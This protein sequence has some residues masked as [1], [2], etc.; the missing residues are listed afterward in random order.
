MENYTER[1]EQLEQN[2]RESDARMN[3][4][5]KELQSFCRNLLTAMAS[6]CIAM[7]VLVVLQTQVLRTSK[8]V[9]GSAEKRMFNKS[10]TDP[11]YLNPTAAVAFLSF[12][13]FEMHEIQP[14]E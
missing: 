9:P 10:L 2:I 14:S 13:G 4:A 8:T 12:Q 6:A 1:K 3:K 11:A 5:E 7:I